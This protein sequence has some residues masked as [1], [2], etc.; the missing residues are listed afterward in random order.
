MSIVVDYLK[1]IETN[2]RSVIL[3]GSGKYVNATGGVVNSSTLVDGDFSAFVTLGN[4][5]NPQHAEAIL[6]KDTEFVCITGYLPTNDAATPLHVDVGGTV[7]AA[8]IL[9]EFVNGTP[10]KPATAVIKLATPL[11]APTL[12]KVG[13][14]GPTPARW[15]I[16][17]IWGQRRISSTL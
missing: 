9:Q 11:A 3:G 13:F 10:L 4:A 12:V 8:N 5:T 15:K 7:I 16:A 17:Q 14:A 2:N 6:P 1:G